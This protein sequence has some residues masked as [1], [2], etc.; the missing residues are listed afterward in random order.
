VLKK[1]TVFSGL[2]QYLAKVGTRNFLFDSAIA[3]PQFEG[4]TSATF[5][6]TLLCNRNSAIPQLLKKR[7]SATATPQFRNRSFF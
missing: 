2:F 7:C 4:S 1:K 6:E 3:I 5:Q